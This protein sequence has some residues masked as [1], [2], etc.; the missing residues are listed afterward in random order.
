MSVYLMGQLRTKNWAWYEEY[1][2]VTE[3]LV[4]K[5]GGKYLV[6]AARRDIEVLEQGSTSMPSAVVLIE[7]PS[8]EQ[9]KQWYQD[10]EY[11]PMIELRQS[12]GVDTELFVASGCVG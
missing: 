9:A 4:V 5:H 11:Q 12:N 2:T 1:V 6:K 8:K 3:Q 7:F 10:P